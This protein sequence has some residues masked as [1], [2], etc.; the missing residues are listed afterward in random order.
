[1]ESRQPCAIHAK[2]SPFNPRRSNAGRSIQPKF[3]FRWFIEKVQ[4]RF[5]HVGM[6][7]FDFIEREHASAVRDV[8]EDSSRSP[9]FSAGAVEIMERK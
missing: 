5:Q 6:R 9:D 8:L 7:L 4:E 3:I 2:D 1:M